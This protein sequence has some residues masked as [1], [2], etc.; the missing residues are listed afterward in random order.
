L[1]FALFIKAEKP[2]LFKERNLFEDKIQT[3]EAKG[4]FI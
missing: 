2:K 3:N 1:N 4:L